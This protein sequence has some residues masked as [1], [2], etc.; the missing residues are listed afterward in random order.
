MNKGGY[1]YI[2]TNSSN[3]VLYVGVTSDINRRTFEH[4]ISRSGFTRKYNCKKLVYLERFETIDLAIAREKQ[5]K[6]GPR[7]RKVKLI[8][9]SNVGWGD[10]MKMGAVEFT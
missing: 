9:E 2:L 10:L 1:V 5:L 3:R 6:K 7:W 4:E 8:E